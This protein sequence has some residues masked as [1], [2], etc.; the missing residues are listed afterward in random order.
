MKIKE[1]EW[2]KK[3]VQANYNVI[4]EYW[5]SHPLRFWKFNCECKEKYWFEA[6]DLKIYARDVLNKMYMQ[7]ITEQE[8]RNCYLDLKKNN[9]I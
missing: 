4:C 2:D 3:E 5:N 6:I 8:R 1:L 7:D 9:I